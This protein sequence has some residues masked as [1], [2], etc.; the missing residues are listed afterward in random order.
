MPAEAL[1]FTGLRGP[2]CLSAGQRRASQMET[3]EMAGCEL[4]LVSTSIAHETRLPK[5]LHQIRCQRGTLRISQPGLTTGPHL[6]WAPSERSA[7]AFLSTLRS[8]NC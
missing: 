8:P 7:R 3:S 1:A 5:M 4:G 6:F 2:E